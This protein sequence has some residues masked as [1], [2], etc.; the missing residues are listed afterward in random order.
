[1]IIFEIIHRELEI[2]ERNESDRFATYYDIY[3]IE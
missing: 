2:K 1:M 3:Q